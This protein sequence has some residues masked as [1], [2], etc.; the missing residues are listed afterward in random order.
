MKKDQEIAKLES[1]IEAMLPLLQAASAAAHA[2]EKAEGDDPDDVEFSRLIDLGQFTDCV[3]SLCSPN[4]YVL[5]R[6]M[7][8]LLGGEHEEEAE[9]QH[10]HQH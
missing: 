4:L 2:L 8:A 1:A 7:F 9:P 6:I 3:G 10:L 5:V